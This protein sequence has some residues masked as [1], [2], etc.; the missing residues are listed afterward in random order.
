MQT[1]VHETLGDAWRHEGGQAILSSYK[2]GDSMPLGGLSR[3]P[4]D[5]LPAV[6]GAEIELLAAYADR[7]NARDFEAVKT[8]LADDVRLDMVERNKTQGAAVGLYFGN[9]SNL[10][11]LRL[12]VGFVD[13]KPALLVADVQEPDRY[14][15]IILLQWHDEKIRKI[16]DYRYAPLVMQD[17]DIIV[18]GRDE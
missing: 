10:K 1:L 17:A 11:D 12:A 13:R 16:R 9:Y 14:L 8:M 18:L 7:F 3:R 6:G 5:S 15:Y 2:V 4:Q